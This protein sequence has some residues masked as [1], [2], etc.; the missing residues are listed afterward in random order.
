MTSVP[1]EAAPERLTAVLRRAGV[2]E[3]GEVVDVAVET[4]RDTLFSHIT[5]LRPTY[6]SAVDGGPTHVFL[7]SQ[8]DGVD[9]AWREFGHKEVSFYNLVASATPGNLLPRCYEARAE[10]G[11]PWH[12]MLEDLTASHEPLGEWPLP[13]AAERWHAVV[14]AHA[15]FH[16]AW[17]DDERLGRS[18]G[19]FADDSGFLDSYLTRMPGDLAAFADRLGDRL[20]AERKQVYERLIAAAPRLLDRYRSH[21]NLTL[22][23]GDAHVWNAMFP[24]QPDRDH[25][26][27]VDW[28]AWRIDT[29]TDDLAYMLALHWYPDWRR[30]HERDSLQRY[31]DVLVAA[32]VR[33]YSFDALWQ[34]YR[35]SV[36]WQITTP[37]WQAN[38]AITPMIW[39]AH[40]DRIMR[41]V[42]DLDCLDL[43]D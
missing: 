18:I 23:H 3:R 30:R 38:H 6:G 14:A 15:R 29:A 32:G 28:D 7:K 1:P 37:M 26:R 5:R 9:P 2:L 17:W 8:R 24:R 16:A 34:D 36:L 12:L 41:A 40:L 27:L 11:Q 42:H 21:R 13:P 31:H 39:W 33:D 10:P 19:T 4:S 25:V 43:L 22:V 20:S 35:L